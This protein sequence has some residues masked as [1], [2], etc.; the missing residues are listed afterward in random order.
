MKKLVMA[1]CLIF[2]TTLPMTNAQAPLTDGGWSEELL[3]ISVEETEQEE[4]D[5]QLSNVSILPDNPMYATQRLE[6]KDSPAN[7]SETIEVY[8]ENEEVN[9]IGGTGDCALVSTDMGVGYVPE[10]AL[11]DTPPTP[12]MTYLG[13]FEITHYCPCAICNGNT[14]RITA[15]GAPLT[16]GVSIAVDPSVIPMGQKVYIEGYGE[17]VAQDTGGAIRGNHIDMFVDVDHNTCE[18]MGKVY[19][20]VYLINE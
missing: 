3:R 15:S 14:H 2:G 1:I 11:S 8:E 16:G 18:A 10:D 9:V 12:P 17:R 19:C 7:D 13:I 5:V 6:V 20:K 4:Q